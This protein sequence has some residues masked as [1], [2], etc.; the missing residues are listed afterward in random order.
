[1]SGAPPRWRADVALAFVCLTWGATFIVVKQALLDI[2]MLLFLALRFAFAAIAL[3]L[4][5]QHRIRRSASP[6]VAVRGGLIAGAFLFTGYFLQ[7]LGLNYTSASKAGF[8][9]GLYIPLVPLVGALLYRKLPN[10]FEAIGVALAAMGMALMT[11]E[12]GVGRINRG[13][14]LIAGCAVVYAFHIVILG[15]FSKQ[16]DTPTLAFTQIATCTVLAAALFPWAEPVRVV[17]S[18][19]VWIALAVTSLLATAL[20]FTIQTWAQQYSSP[21]RTAVIFSLE[22]VFA[23]GTSWLLAG[24]S[25]SPRALAGAALILAGIMTVELKPFRSSNHPSP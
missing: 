20:A 1:M 16:A 7:T 13:D 2:S 14:A 21:T 23:W 8:I 3:A 15:H 22:P 9:T 17:W 6:R 25:L 10:R 5:F 12:P 19:R 4:V 24:E 11:I 18:P